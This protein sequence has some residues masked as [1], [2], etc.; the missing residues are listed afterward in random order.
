MNALKSHLVYVQL[1]PIYIMANKNDSYQF[2]KQSNFHYIVPD[3]SIQIQMVKG[4]KE[5]RLF[6][7][8]APSQEVME[9]YCSLSVDWKVEKV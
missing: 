9:A 4:K 8:L 1:S 5:V 2:L 3:N 7:F 6:T